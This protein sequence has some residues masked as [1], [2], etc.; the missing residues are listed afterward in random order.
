M[1]FKV[2]EEQNQERTE[3]KDMTK[4]RFFIQHKKIVYKARY[5]C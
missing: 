1:R 2:E 3:I 5:I 4:T